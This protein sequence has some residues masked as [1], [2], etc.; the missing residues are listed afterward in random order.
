MKLF[1]LSIYNLILYPV[2]FIVVA[3]L[4]PFNHKI[5]SGFSGRYYSLKKLKD[6]KITN[7]SSDIY[8]FHVS[9]F[10]EFQQIESIISSIKNNND[11]TK[12]IVSFFSPSG[13]SN[14]NDNNIDCKVYLPFDFA[15]SI[16]RVLKLIKPKK[17]IFASY[18]VWPNILLIARFLNIDTILISV[19]IHSNSFKLTR[20]GRSIYKV[21]YTLISQIF[22]VNNQDLENI[23]LIVPDKI[24]EAMG[25]PRFDIALRRE[26]NVDVKFDMEY[27]LKNR[28]FLFASLWPEDDSILFPRI[29]DLLKNNHTAKII[30]I[31]H[32][33]SDRSINYY[34]KQA[35]RNNLS[36]IVIEDYIDLSKLKEQVV[37][38]NTVGILYKLY[39]Q[40]HISYIGGGFSKN[41]IHNIMEPAVA[42]N[43]IIF[44]PNYSNGNFSEAEELLSA[45]AAFTINSDL[46]LIEV[47]KKLN[48]ISTYD[49]ASACSRSVME[50]NIGSTS[51]LLSKILA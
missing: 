8:W 35:S 1:W 51:K 41:G 22:T 28:F 26:S 31:P 40:A 29:F 27:K 6:F 16:F 34:Q 19:R 43:P 36:S 14:V 21:I 18:D 48:D 2:F 42:S 49:L 50:N 10:G 23:K 37:I 17:I 4:Y 46:E 3:L 47:F 39:W 9:S 11:N 25:N 24:I 5:R 20:L 30:L 32:E 45:S 13:Y 44:G 15:W 38:V 7:P 12:I 33:L